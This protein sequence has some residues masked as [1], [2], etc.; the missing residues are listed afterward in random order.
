[1][2]SCPWRGREDHLLVLRHGSSR[3]NLALRET[4]CIAM[5]GSQTVMARLA[6]RIMRAHEGESQAQRASPSRRL[7]AAYRER[8]PL[9]GM[10]TALNPFV[11]LSAAAGPD[12]PYSQREVGERCNEPGSGSQHDPGV[13]GSTSSS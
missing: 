6:V 5:L 10:S 13:L 8:P 11:A 9:P 7:V 12:K 1:M 3:W 4:K 2:I